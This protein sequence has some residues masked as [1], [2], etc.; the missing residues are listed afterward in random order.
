MDTTK[1]EPLLTVSFFE[2]QIRFANE[3]IAEF[4]ALLNDASIVS[5][6]ILL[7]SLFSYRYSLLFLKYSR[8]YPIEE[9]RPDLLALVDAL[10]AYKAHPLA[11]DFFF[12]GEQDEYMQALTL[13][14][15]G[16]LLHVETAVFERLVAAIGASGQD[17]ILEWLIGRRLPQRPATTRLLFP[18]TYARLRDAIQAP[19]DIQSTVL[20]QFLAGWYE[21][22]DTVWYNIHAHRQDSAGFTGYWCWEAAAVAYGLGADDATLRPLPYYPTDLADFAFGRWPPQG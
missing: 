7:F 13:V 21:S 2:E 20:Q 19:R 11:E 5:P 22:L 12:N 9:M 10:E 15:L 6:E 1:R 14:S 16:L 17:Y 4:T 18:K 8:G 3:T